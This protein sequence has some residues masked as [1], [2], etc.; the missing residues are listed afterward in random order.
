MGFSRPYPGGLDLPNLLVVAAVDQS[1]RPTDFTSYGGVVD[2]WANG[3]DVESFVP[4][5]MRQRMSGTSQA[6]P[7]GTNL[8]AKILAIDPSLTP[9]EVIDLIRRE[10]EPTKGERPMLLLHPKRTIAALRNE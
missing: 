9:V 8:A 1:G 10:A 5:G 6:A 7:Q 3:Y 4:G 2:V